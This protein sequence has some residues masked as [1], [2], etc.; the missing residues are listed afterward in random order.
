MGKII[1]HVADVE[2]RE[3][4]GMG[5]VAFHWERAFRKRGHEFIHI[6]PAQ[7]GS[8]FHRALFPW[9]A[10]AAYKRMGIKADLFLVHEP[11]AGAFVDRGVPTFIVS[12]GLER[13]GATLEAP[14]ENRSLVQ[15]IREALT[16]P[17]WK[18]RSYSRDRGLRRATAALLINQEDAAFA[19][20]YYG[21]LPEKVWVFRNG[22]NP[23]KGTRPY[24]Q[25]A[26]CHVLFLGSWIKRKGTDTLAQAASI[27]LQRRVHV[28]WLLAGTG[29][30]RDA[31]LA[32]WPAELVGFTKVVP[33]FE[34]AEED[35]LFATSDLFVLP[36]FFEGQP[37]ALLQAMA[38]GLCCITSD[39][40]GQKDLI[41]DRQ[42]GL[43]HP[44]G[45]AKGLAGLIQECVESVELRAQ[46]GR[47]AALSVADRT[48]EVVSE[49]V[50]DYV[51]SVMQR[52]QPVQAG[53]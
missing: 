33:H 14:R 17:M 15:R 24:S 41:R 36:S 16:S 3:T 39:C 27:L 6:G 29:L 21:I 32:H 18:L 53:P 38:R 5:R 30:D 13:R 26:P 48:W 28:N 7:V 1:I 49:E 25:N 40:C 52:I 19:R 10:Y 20:D 34:A 51:E 12:H 47:R 50:V 46:L 42:N 35:E 44:P 2:I 9:A 22:I 11:A 23:A 37:L 45:D 8:T 4:G 31:V 43:L